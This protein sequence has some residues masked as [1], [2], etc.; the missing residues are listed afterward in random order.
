MLVGQ[1]KT[2][3]QADADAF[4]F[5]VSVQPHLMTNSGDQALMADRGSVGVC[6]ASC[7]RSGR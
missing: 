4:E 2:S 1:I 5:P 3:R 7:E 6:M